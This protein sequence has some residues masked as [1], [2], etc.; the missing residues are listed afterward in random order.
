M[1]LV[2][3]NVIHV[4]YGTG[5]VVEQANGLLTIQFEGQEAVKVFACPSAFE[6]FLSFENPT[7]QLEVEGELAALRE[8]E[9]AAR[10]LKEAE[11]AARREAER[12]AVAEA[13]KATRKT[14]TKKTAV[15]KAT[16]VKPAQGGE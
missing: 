9:L 4:Q 13:K 11:D 10:A 12:L 15:K 14:A 16:A 5:K 8:K 1:E 2:N 3:E 6:R 7:L